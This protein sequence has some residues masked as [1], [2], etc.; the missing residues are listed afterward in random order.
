M[1]K[2][3]RCEARG[4]FFCSVAQLYFHSKQEMVHFKLFLDLKCW[5]FGEI[6]YLCARFEF[7]K[8]DNFFSDRTEKVSQ[9]G[10]LPLAKAAQNNNKQYDGN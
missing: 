2:P 3:P 4:L 7:S 10:Q 9:N 8:T 6:L 5:R 1:K